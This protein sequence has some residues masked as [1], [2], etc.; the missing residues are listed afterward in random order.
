M[1]ILRVSRRSSIG[2]PL[3]QIKRIARSQ[4]HHT[5]I[6]GI[7]QLLTSHHRSKL[8]MSD[9]SSMVKRTMKD[10]C[11]DCSIKTP[12]KN[13]L[14]VGLVLWSSDVP[15]LV[16]FQ[17]VSLLLRLVPSKTPHPL[18]RQIRI[19]RSKSPM[20]LEV[21]GTPILRSRP[22]RQSRISTTVNSFL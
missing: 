8:T 4:S 17:S 16:V 1:T 10:S 19:L 20:R 22:L 21:S 11:R 12:S 18:I 9:G 15:A 13:H 5:L 3:F 6:L 7:G 14:V 2:S